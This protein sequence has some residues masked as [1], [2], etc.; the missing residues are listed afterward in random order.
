[1]PTIDQLA[2]ATS[3]SNN[4]EFIVTQS[5]IARKITRA[6]V[7]NGVQ[8]QIAMSAKSL[9]GRMSSGMGAPETIAVGEN[10]SF[11]GYIICHRDAVCNRRPTD[12]Q[13]P[14]SW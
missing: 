5:G 12:W 4:D 13:R 8:P 6:K 2:P 3:A 1:M 9:L 10:L 11:R 7:L 14:F